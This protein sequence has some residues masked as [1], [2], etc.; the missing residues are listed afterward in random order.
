MPAAPAYSRGGGHFIGL[1]G[2]PGAAA[3]GKPGGGQLKVTT[4]LAGFSPGATVRA[5][6]T[7]PMESCVCPL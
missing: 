3:P 4:S 7:G 5:V 1:Q 6:S 2:I